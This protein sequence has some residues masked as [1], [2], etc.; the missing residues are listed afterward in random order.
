MFGFSGQI[1]WKMIQLCNYLLVP[2]ICWENVWN[3]T[4]NCDSYVSV[5]LFL[6]L[7][8]ARF[9]LSK[10]KSN[11]WTLLNYSIAVSK[12]SRME[13]LLYHGYHSKIYIHIHTLP[14]FHQQQLNLELCISVWARPCIWWS[15]IASGPREADFCWIV[16][17]SL[18]VKLIV[19]SMEYS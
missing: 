18:N 3:S 10:R 6:K 17:I 19:L 13:I 11:W 2:F 7:I 14:T 16:I 5:V 8:D 12:H 9:F 15:C 4:G 1:I